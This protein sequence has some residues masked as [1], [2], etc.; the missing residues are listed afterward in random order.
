MARLSCRGLV[1]AYGS[2]QVL[3]GVCFDVERGRT[4]AI[5]G[6]SGS[7]KTTLLKCLNMLSTFEGGS[8]CLDGQEYCVD[9]EPI[10]APWEVRGQIGLVFQEFNLFP[11]ITAGENITLAMRHVRKLGREEVAKRLRSVTDVLEI[12]NVLEKYP[13]ELSGGQAQRVAL[14]RALVLHPAVL[15]LDEITSALD[16]ESVISVIRGIADIRAIEGNDEL[17]V[18]LVTHLVRFAEKVADHIAFLDGG[19]FAAYDEAKRFRENVGYPPARA[20]LSEFETL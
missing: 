8:L 15:L 18:I 9:G 11:T 17:A 2:E 16:P 6:K 1:K 14:A 20:F 3:S 12:G 7:G 13:A 10:F 19:K 5:L 4:L